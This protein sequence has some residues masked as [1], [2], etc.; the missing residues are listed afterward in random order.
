[1]FD[2]EG[3]CLSLNGS[4]W[5]NNG[6]EC[7]KGNACSFNLAFCQCIDGGKLAGNQ[8]GVDRLSKGACQI[9]PQLKMLT[10]HVDQAKQ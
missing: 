2:G 6:G 9:G 10:G 7:Y 5:Q 1:M 3:A 4:A 8:T